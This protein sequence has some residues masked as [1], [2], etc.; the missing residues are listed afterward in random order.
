MIFIVMTLS[1]EASSNRGK[2]RRTGSGASATG[3]Q[4]R[5]I[6]QVG[7]GQTQRWVEGVILEDADSREARFSEAGRGPEEFGGVHRVAQ[8]ERERERY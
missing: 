7:L 2:L 6:L 4:N 5:S 1:D 8:R 3:L